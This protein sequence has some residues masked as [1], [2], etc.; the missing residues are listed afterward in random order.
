MSWLQAFPQSKVENR[1]SAGEGQQSWSPNLSKIT[2]LRFQIPNCFR[3]WADK[4]IGWPI[5]I[6]SA[7]A[8]QL[9]QQQL[10]F[11]LHN[12]YN[13]LGYNMECVYTVQTMC[14]TA[15]ISETSTENI[16]T[17]ECLAIVL[18]GI[19]CSAVSDGMCW[20]WYTRYLTI[21]YV[22]SYISS[23]SSHEAEH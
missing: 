9:F 1:R 14:S 8:I 20:K 11:L 5:L 6:S 10:P 3:L 17:Y 7:S 2:Y 21:L 4:V 19:G 12:V 22:Y 23:C 13:H 16:H 15:H 18:P